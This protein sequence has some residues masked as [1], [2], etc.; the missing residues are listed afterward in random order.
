MSGGLIEEDS[1]RLDGNARNWPEQWSDARETR[2]EGKYSKPVLYSP[3]LV[4]LLDNLVILG[5][6]T[7]NG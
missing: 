7:D 5:S 1:G 6:A 3:I 2:G 4:H